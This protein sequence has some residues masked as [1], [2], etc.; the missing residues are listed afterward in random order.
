MINF[1]ARYRTL[2]EFRPGATFAVALDTLDKIYLLLNPMTI[3]DG[4]TCECCFAV[5][6][7]TGD[8]SEMD[9]SLFVIPIDIRAGICLS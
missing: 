4:D 3:N 7:S 9:P 1:D 6:L 8:V 5:N 2:K